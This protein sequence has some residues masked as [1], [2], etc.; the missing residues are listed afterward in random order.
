[1]ANPSF[2]CLKPQH[3]EYVENFMALTNGLKYQ[4]DINVFS[5]PTRETT[6]KQVDHLLDQW[7]VDYPELLTEYIVKR[8][9]E[10]LG[11]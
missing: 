11:V 3:D 2:E 4:D 5:G 10:A 1:M 9:V 6:M 8:G 7:S